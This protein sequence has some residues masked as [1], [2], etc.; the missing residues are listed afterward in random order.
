[1]NI[2]ITKEVEGTSFNGPWSGR[3]IYQENEILED[4]EQVEGYPNMF[5]H[6][7]FKGTTSRTLYCLPSSDCWEIVK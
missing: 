5:E 3:A 6:T 2:K 1:M 7:P 4:V